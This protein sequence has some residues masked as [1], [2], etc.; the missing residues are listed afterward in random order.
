M[1]D[2]MKRIS[3]FLMAALLAA[4]VVSRAQDAAVEER[5][6]KL[7]AQIEVLIEAKDVQNRK[8][9]ELAR[10]LREVQE[11]QNKPSPS[12]AS[13]EDVKQL[14]DKLKEVDEKRVQDNEH[15]VK[16][17]EKLAKTLAAPVRKPTPPATSDTPSS[18]KPEKGYEYFIKAGDTYSTV[19]QAYRDQGVKVTADQI[20]K[21]N[22][23]VSPNKL[24]VGQKIFIPAATQ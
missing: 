20:E 17:I 7:S 11:Q 18:T 13:A 21:A 10:Q 24:K 6:N 19:A 5:L 15:I 8:I 23:G 9:E 22:P 1:F 14:A 12:H 4:P 16:E 3:F 2:F